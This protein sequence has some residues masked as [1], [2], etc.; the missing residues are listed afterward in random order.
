MDVVFALGKSKHIRNVNETLIVGIL[1]SGL[2]P[3]EPFSVC[4]L[5]SEYLPFDELECK[6]CESRGFSLLLITVFL[7]S[8]ALHS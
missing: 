2:R 7:A 3:G 5:T 6:L 1:L 8:A 4:P